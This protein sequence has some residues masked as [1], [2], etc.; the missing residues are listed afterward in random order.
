MSIT[1]APSDPLLSVV[2]YQL[3]RP[4]CISLAYNIPPEKACETNW[5]YRWF[6]REDWENLPQVTLRTNVFSPISINCLSWLIEVCFL[7]ACWQTLLQ[8]LVALLSCVVNKWIYKKM[9]CGN[10]PLQ[11]DCGLLHDTAATVWCT[12]VQSSLLF[13]FIFLYLNMCYYYYLPHRQALTEA[14][15]VCARKSLTSVF[16][17]RTLSAAAN[18][19]SLGIQFLG[20]W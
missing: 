9:S 11:T 3:T 5:V 7:W 6:G 2:D 13:I 4:L 8:K 16:E 1:E 14:S 17:V 10:S 20:I 19:I 12:Q 15:V 18:T